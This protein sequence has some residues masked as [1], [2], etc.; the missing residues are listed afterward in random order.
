MAGVPFRL[1]T[2]LS[3][4]PA[5]L[6][7]NLLSLVGYDEVDKKLCRVE[8]RRS[9]DNTDRVHCHNSGLEGD[10]VD[11]RT[12]LL[13]EVGPIPIGHDLQ[14]IFSRSEELRHHSAPVANR[15]F[16]LR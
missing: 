4:F 15:N 7:K 11:G 1:Q 10:P 6:D 13:H 9:I 8:M 3:R 16:L 14:I 12:L 5:S 2:R